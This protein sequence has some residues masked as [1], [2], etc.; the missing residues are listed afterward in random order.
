[1]VSD[2]GTAMT[3]GRRWWEMTKTERK[4]KRRRSREVGRRGKG[5]ESAEKNTDWWDD[6]EKRSEEMKAIM[7]WSASS[8]VLGIYEIVEWS[9]VC[10]C[11]WMYVYVCG[12]ACAFSTSL[13]VLQEPD[14]NSQT[15]MSAVCSGP[16]RLHITCSWKLKFHH[17]GILS[18]SKRHTFW[19]KICNENYIAGGT[20]R[21]R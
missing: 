3:Q 13:W 7:S 12:C 21:T 14:D 4:E 6:K 5:R 1:M 20:T 11:T 9:C 2:T 8:W 18:G 10:V 17:I 19:W 16:C 15:G